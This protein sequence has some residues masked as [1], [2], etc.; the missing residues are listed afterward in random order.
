MKTKN[1]ILASIS[2][3]LIVF[4]VGFAALGE[5]SRRVENDEWRMESEEATSD[6][7]SMER[8]VESDVPVDTL[9]HVKVKKTDNP[10]GEQEVESSLDL[11]DPD[12]LKYNVGEYDEKS[13][14]YRVGT[15]LGDNFLSAPTLMTPEEYATWNTRKLLSDYFKMRNDSYTKARRSS[16]LPICIS[17]S[18]RLRRYS[19]LVV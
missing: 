3:W 2:V 9:P 18:A 8:E 6:F 17:T 15:K 12:N 5:S 7:P 13:G 4:A 1:K 10:T 19:A 11:A 14:Y 16:I